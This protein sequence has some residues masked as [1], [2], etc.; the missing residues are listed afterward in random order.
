VAALFFSLY[1]VLSGF[2][3]GIIVWLLREYVPP[4][5]KDWIDAAYHYGGLLIYAL[6]VAWAGYEAHWHGMPT[7]VAQ[8]ALARMLLFDPALNTARSYFNHR[9]GRTWG[10]LFEVGTTAVS[11]RVIRRLAPTNPERLRL[12]VW[13]V[14]AGLSIGF[15]YW[16]RV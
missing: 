11:D 5:R 4:G 15:V 1:T 7:L 8:A 13:L 14:S 9:E 2:Q 12:V 16:C 3:Q 10:Q 6:L